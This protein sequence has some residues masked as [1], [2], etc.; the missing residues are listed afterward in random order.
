MWPRTGWTYGSGKPRPGSACPHNEAGIEALCERLDALAPDRIVVEATGGREVPL[1]AALQ[2]AGLPVAVV[3]PRQARAFGRALGQLA[4][5][6]R[7][8]ARLRARMAAVLRPPVRP[9][10]DADLRA[11]RAVVVRRRPI[12]A[13]G[14]QEKTRLARAPADLQPRIRAHLEWLQAELKAL[15]RELHDRMQAHAAWQAQTELLRSVPGVGPVVAAVLVAELP[16]LGRLNGRE[17]AALVGVAPLNR[18]RGQYR[19]P[20]RVWGGRASVRTMLYMATVTATRHNPAIRDFYTRLCRRGKPRKVA[21]VAAMRKLLLIL[22]AVVR[23]QVPWHPDRMPM[24][25]ET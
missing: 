21:L 11:L 1:A 14:A 2:A 18:D 12:A 20:R 10:P 19:G 6:D 23:D 16:E 8:D 5:T 13:M 15:N 9:L 4:K 24:A 7:L 3:N 17:I 22:N 25:G